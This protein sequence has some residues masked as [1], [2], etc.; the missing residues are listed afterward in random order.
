MPVVG[1]RNKSPCFQ[2]FGVVDQRAGKYFRKKGGLL[3]LKQY[4]SPEHV[5]KINQVAGVLGEPMFG[6][7]IAECPSS[8]VLGQPAV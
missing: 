5:Q 7:Y 8:N 6:L 3:R 1:R 2:E 4:D